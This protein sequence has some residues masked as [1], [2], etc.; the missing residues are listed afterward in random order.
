MEVAN[1]QLN[2]YTD[3]VIAL[4][5]SSFDIPMLSIVKILR[6]SF[7]YICVDTWYRRIQTARQLG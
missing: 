2:H 7:I 1:A 4:V 5:G 3:S 6:D